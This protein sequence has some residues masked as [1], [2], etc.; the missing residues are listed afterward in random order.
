MVIGTVNILTVVW[1]TQVH[2]SV[3]THGKTYLKSVHLTLGKFT[4]KEKNVN[5]Y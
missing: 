3:R 1:V 2:A 4:S 5:K